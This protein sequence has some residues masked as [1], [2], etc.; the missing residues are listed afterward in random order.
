MLNAFKIKSIYVLV[1][2]AFAFW[3]VYYNIFL[4]DDVGLSGSQIGTINGIIQ[5]SIFFIVTFWS[6]VA[7]KRGI[8]PT[9]RIVVFFC[10]ILMYF[11]G[12]VYSYWVLLIY[13]PILTIFYHPVGPLTDALATE[14]AKVTGTYSFGALRLWGSVGWALASIIAGIAFKTTNI[15]LK[16]IFL[17]SGVLYIAVIPFLTTRN[18]KR[19]FKPNFQPLKLNDLFGNRPLML[20][21]ILIVLYGIVC[22]P[23]HAYLNLYFNELNAGNDIVGFAY[24][25]MA[26]SEIPMFLIGSK[27]LK[28]YG[29]D[30]VILVAIVTMLFRFIFYGFM[31]TPTVALIICVFQGI[32]LPFFVIGIVDY[33]QRLLPEGRHATAQSI[34]WGLFLGVGQAS[35]N[36]LIGGFIDTIGMVS[37]MQW[38]LVVTA[39]CLGYALW[40]FKRT[41]QPQ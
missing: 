24:A 38:Y 15:P 18:K 13:I 4:L 41:P 2:M 29:A 3:R 17:A 22:S 23:V 5:F 1:Y 36:L 27:L 9:L 6:M 12:E 30:K 26:A 28:K 40:Y 25:I 16:Y 37:I 32:T 8:R 34:I 14:F 35:G 21:S 39:I 19:T 10:A 31:P 11:L 20:L 7:D 33:L